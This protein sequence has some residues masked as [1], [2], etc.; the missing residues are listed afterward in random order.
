MKRPVRYLYCLILLLLLAACVPA[1]TPATDAPTASAAVETRTVTDLRGN[2]V[3]IPVDPQRIIVVDY[4]AVEELLALGITPAGILYDADTHLA[5][6]LVDVPVI[7]IDGAPTLEMVVQIKP[8]LIIAQE[9]WIDDAVYEQLR[10]I[11]PTVMIDRQ[12]FRDWKQ[13]LRN[14]GELV[15]RTEQAEQLLADY[16]AHV[17]QVHDAI[18][19]ATLADTVVTVFLGYNDMLRIWV[20]SFC[21][22]MLD[23]VGLRIP[24]TQRDLL[25]AGEERI[26]NLSL[27]QI[28][29]LDADV[30]F[31]IVPEATWNVE[32]FTTLESNPLFQQLPAVQAG[33]YYQ[34]D[35]PWNEGS[36][37]S[38]HL[39]LDALQEYLAPDA[40]GTTTETTTAT[41]TISETRTITHA[42]GELTVPATPLRLVSLNTDL[43]DSLVALGTIPVG[44]ITF[45]GDDFEGYEYLADDLKAVAIVGQSNAPNLEQILL[46]KPDLIIGRDDN[47]EIYDTL[48]AIAPTALIIDQHGDT[49][50]WLRQVAHT[51]NQAAAGEARIAAYDEKVAAA[52]AILQPQLG[53]ETV[54]FLRIRPDSIRAYNGYRHGGPLLYN[55]L[56]L[57]SPA[58]VQDLPVDEQSVDLSLETVA[59]LTDADHIFLPDQTENDESAPLFASPLWQML[60]AVQ[61]DHVY[62]AARDIWTNAGVIAAEHEI[63]AV[64]A[65]LA[66]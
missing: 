9:W 50:G 22:V 45:T 48:S 11:A 21:N 57:N 6:Q 52:A 26:D 18:G 27:E 66:P 34:V 30:L 39:V 13:Y 24:Q 14:M 42:L 5:D 55:D 33:K 36:V 47:V 10:Q 7:G 56:G 15:G 58:L 17:T 59:D 8:D 32:F 43:T 64:L 62:T 28:P 25:P 46:L 35:A 54:V 1:T 12:N 31:T 65:A 40:A 53:N 29:L 4:N 37:I 16:D 19:E 60:P 3:E 63:E 23:D 61:N 41:T 49:R 51:I 44:I 38:A 20:D 2:S